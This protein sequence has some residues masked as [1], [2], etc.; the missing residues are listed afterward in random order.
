MRILF[1]ASS[2]GLGIT[3]HLARL[4][5]GLKRRGHNVLVLS[6]G[7]E[8]D[9]GYI[10]F[11]RNEGIPIREVPEIE[12]WSSIGLAA[13]ALR[14]IF[15]EFSYFDVIHTMGLKQ[16]LATAFSLKGH[17]MRP[18]IVLTVHAARH[19]ELLSPLYYWM[20][21]I[22]VNRYADLVLSVSNWWQR[23]LQRYGCLL[24][25]SPSPRD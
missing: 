17:P 5:V 2:T 21:N 22:V 14:K 12:R 25:T 16:L 9:P 3:Y 18:P 13:I 7:G 10:D 11:I 8:Q 24:Y 6:G 23:Q 19:G 1:W 4:A 15:G 20:N